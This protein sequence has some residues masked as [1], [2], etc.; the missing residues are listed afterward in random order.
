MLLTD[1][2]TDT[3]THKLMEQYGDPRNKPLLIW[4]LNLW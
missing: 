4:L 1:T 3:Q 2:K